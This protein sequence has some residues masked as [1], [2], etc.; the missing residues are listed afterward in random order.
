MTS[1]AHLSLKE[2]VN[3]LRKW[4]KPVGPP[5]APFQPLTLP[6]VGH[7]SSLAPPGPDRSRLSLT[8]PW[9]TVFVA[10]ALFPLKKCPALSSAH[11]NVIWGWVFFQSK[12][13]G[14]HPSVRS[15]VHCCPSRLREE[16]QIAPFYLPFP[17]SSRR[18]MT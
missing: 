2:K 4:G 5:G 14:C 9:G 8:G 11:C 12:R 10:E 1:V 18:I 7:I 13:S 16:L 15:D 6:E 17:L 3:I